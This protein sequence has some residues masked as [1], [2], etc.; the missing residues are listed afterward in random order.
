MNFSPT[1]APIEPPIKPNSK[2]RT[3]KGIP[4]NC[5]FTAT[6]ASFSP[7][8][9]CAANK[10]SLYRFK[11]RITSRG[12]RSLPDALAGQTSEHHP[13][14]VQASWS[15]NCFQE[16]SFTLLAPRLVFSKSKLGSSMISDMFIGLSKPRFFLLVRVI[17]ATAAIT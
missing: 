9:F 3:T 14:F 4:S 10:R 8:L 13:H 5:P 15:S 17:L 1:T 6:R 16:K 2:A 7:V 11:S 12:A